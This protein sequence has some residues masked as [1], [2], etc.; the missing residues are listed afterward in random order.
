MYRPAHASGYRRRAARAKQSRR[1]P[2]YVTPRTP[3]P[4]PAADAPPEP[5]GPVLPTRRRVPRWTTPPA[6]HP[7][8]AAP[9]GGAFGY[10]R[11][12]APPTETPAAGRHGPPGSPDARAGQI[13]KS[14]LEEASG[15]AATIRATAE[16]DAAQ[17]RQQATDQ[18]AT[19]RADA[20]REAAELR[21]VITTLLAELDRVTAH[22]SGNRTDTAMAATRSV[23]SPAPR[24]A[25]PTTQ[26]ASPPGSALAVHP[27]APPA[28]QPLGNLATRPGPAAVA[29]AGAKPAVPQGA[30]LA[31]PPT[32]KTAAHPR[33]YAAA[34]LM[35]AVITTL[36]LL[37][38]AAGYAELGLHGSAF[39]VFRSAGTGAT[40]NNGLQEDQ[41]PGQPDA[42]GVHRD[43]RRPHG[44]RRETRPGHEAAGGHHHLI[45]LPSLLPSPSPSLKP[46][47]S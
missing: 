1:A 3:G 17:I 14:A 42:P 33:Q 43:V 32:R 26:P 38:L 24:T 20:E 18:A 30:T 5:S 8:R 35:V 28:T 36:A 41:G 23:A 4:L 46:P 7:E 31:A 2:A 34:R 12:G 39:F 29:P 45:G 27:G 9:P 40:D 47:I 25:L 16:A 6:A 37:V 44:Q 19:I 13:L 11:P 21:V 10:G 22:V 15:L